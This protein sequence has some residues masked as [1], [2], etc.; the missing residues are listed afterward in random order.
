MTVTSAVAVRAHV[1]RFLPR[2]GRSAV[3]GRLAVGQVEEAGLVG[4][5]ADRPYSY[6][7]D[8][9]DA[10]WARQSAAPLGVDGEWV[11]PLGPLSAG[12]AVELLADHAGSSRRAPRVPRP[13]GGRARQRTLGEIVLRSYD[14]LPGDARRAFERLGVFAGPVSWESAAPVCADPAI[15]SEGVLGSSATTLRG[16]GRAPSWVQPTTIR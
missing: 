11:Q 12:T 3:P 13:D 15:A 1:S 7:R 8:L 2:S 16:H 10:H 5:H 14:L 6:P 4:I 9:S